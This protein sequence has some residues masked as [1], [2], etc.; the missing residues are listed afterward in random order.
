MILLFW[1]LFPNKLV[2]KLSLKLFVLLLYRLL[3]LWLLFL[4]KIEEVKSI[5]GLLLF[6]SSK[7]KELLIILFELLLI[8]FSLLIILLLP[9]LLLLLLFILLFLL[10]SWL[11]ISS[12]FVNNKLLISLIFIISF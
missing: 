11:F 10:L 9:L 7:F 6:L 3:K 1:L 8:L 4:W 2:L 12:P 5:E